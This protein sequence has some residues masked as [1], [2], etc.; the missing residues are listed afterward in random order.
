V[1]IGIEISLYPLT[2]EAIPLIHDFIGRLQRHASLRLPGGFKM[3]S[4]SMS[5]QVFGRFEEV[6]GLLQ[7]ELKATFEQLGTQ[8]HTAAAVMKVV[9]PL[10]SV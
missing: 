10:K 5:T 3:E 4:N 1:D 8:G 9:G 7:Q 6:L 2:G